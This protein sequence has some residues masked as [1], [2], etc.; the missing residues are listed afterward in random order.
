MTLNLMVLHYKT[1]K[2]SLL[3]A[4]GLV[5]GAM[6]AFKH[7]V[8]AYTAIAI[9]AGLIA[10]HILARTMEANR[11]SSLLVRLF[12]YFAGTVTIVVSLLVYFAIKSGPN[13]LQDLIVFPL[14]DFRFAK[15]ESYPSLLMRDRYYKVQM[16]EFLH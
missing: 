14:T 16:G 12:A 3:V 1:K 11:T 6:V 7:D 9:V 2:L 13:M 5:T 8:V 4:A 15:P 10:H